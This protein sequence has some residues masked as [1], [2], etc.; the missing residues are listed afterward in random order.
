MSGAAGTPDPRRVVET[1]CRPAVP[2]DGPERGTGYLI[3]PRVV[4][5]ARHAVTSAEDQP[6]RV[7]VRQLS[8]QADEDWLDVAEVV[9]PASPGL[10]IALLLLAGDAPDVTGDPGVTAGIADLA[11]PVPFQA[12]GFPRAHRLGESRV[13]E[14]AR[15]HIRLD[16]GSRSAM[17]PLDVTSAVPSAGR[18]AVP[19]TGVQPK[20]GWLG[21]SGAAVIGPGNL[22]VGVA[23]TDHLR[24]EA[25]RLEMVPVEAVLADEA[26]ARHLP[27][28]WLVRPQ[29]RVSNQLPLAIGSRRVQLLAPVPRT[30]ARKSGRNQVTT[31]LDGRSG[32]VPFVPRVPEQ[33][34]LRRWCD[35]D[36]QPVSF[37]VLS[38]EGGAGKSRLARQ[39]CDDLTDTGWITGLLQPSPGSGPAVP[40]E[41]AGRPALLVLD[42]ADHRQEEVAQLLD[43]LPSLGWSKV[44]VLAVVRDG[45]AFLH[46]LQLARAGSI[47]SVDEKR[48]LELAARPLNFQERQQHYRAAIRAFAEDQQLPLPTA[49]SPP[50]LE[51]RLAAVGTPLLVHAAAL[52]DLLDPGLCG[53]KDPEDVLRHLLDREDL[54]FWE[55]DFTGLLES[56]DTRRRVIAVSTFVSVE[57]AAD[58]ENLAQALA[59]LGAAG[60]P[61]STRDLVAERMKSRYGRLLPRVEPDLLGEQLIADSVVRPGRLAAVVDQVTAAGPRSRMLEVLLRMCGS[62]IG[63]VQQD[64]R[65]ALTRVLDDHL[66]GLLRQA[67]EQTAA[68]ASPGPEARAMPSRLASCIDIAATPQAAARALETVTFPDRVAVQVLA[69][70]VY[71]AAARDAEAK[72][73]FAAAATLDAK[74]ATAKTRAGYLEGAQESIDRAMIYLSTAPAMSV[75]EGKPLARVLSAGSLVSTGLSRPGVALESALQSVRIVEAL[76]D[77]EPGA[78]DVQ[79]LEARQSLVIA[80]I[81][82][83]QVDDALEVARQAIAQS[84]ADS[85][86]P[87]T[88]MRVIQAQILQGRGDLNAAL[89]VIEAGIAEIPDSPTRPRNAELSALNVF[90]AVLLSTLGRIEEAGEAAQ[91]AEEIALRA[92]AASADDSDFILAGTQLGA[93]TVVVSTNGALALDMV[94]HASEALRKLLQRAPDAYGPHYAL[95][96]TLHARILSGIEDMAG[97]REVAQR[98]DRFIRDG[99][100]SRPSLYL[101][102]LFMSALT[103]AEIYVS[104]EEYTT[105]TKVLTDAHSLLSRIDPSVAPLAEGNCAFLL[106]SLADVEMARED[107]DAAVLAARHALV[108]FDALIARQP[109]ADHILGRIGTRL[110]LLTALSAADRD[111]ELIGEAGEALADAERLMETMPSDQSRIILGLA[112]VIVAAGYEQQGNVPEAIA[113]LHVT[114]DGLHF[115]H[116]TSATEDERNAVRQL[117]RDLEAPGDRIASDASPEKFEDLASVRLG[118]SVVLGTYHG[119][120]VAARPFRPV[121]VLGPQRSRKT[122]GVIIPALLEWQ[123]PVLVTSVR[124]DV[125][126]GSIQRRARMGGRSWVF[127]PFGDLFSGAE[128]P[129]TTWNPVDGCENWESAVRMAHWL[130]E[131]GHTTDHAGVQDFA[132][133]YSQSTLLLG[134]LL[135]AAALSG[136]SMDA[137]SRWARTAERAEVIARLEVS[138]AHPESI[139]TFATFSQLVDMTR[140]G[141]YAT[142]RTVL[143]AYESESV[144]RNSVTGFRPEEFF[145]G[146]PNTLYLCAPP[147]EQDLLAPIF[148][149]LVKTIVARAYRYQ[150]DNLN[151]LLLLDEAGNIARI[152]NLNTLATTA[153]GTKIQLVTVFHDLSQM[154]ALYGQSRASNIANNHSAL[155]ILPGT[156]DEATMHY[157]ERLLRDESGPARFTAQR[158]VRQLKPGTALCVYEHLKIEEIK[159][160]SSTHDPDLVALATAAL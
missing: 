66:E 109:V 73:D 60:S 151:L 55:K 72:E 141:V 90:R 84:P 150:G 61:A 29:P 24:F 11:T 17:V 5:T 102:P 38:G 77:R 130:T 159:L 47:D 157:A 6:G 76:A 160:R 65:V 70:E 149:A 82:A 88:A 131:A 18:A 119:Q 96:E 43:L 12:C 7:R 57:N 14:T 138:S 78:H 32:V 35:T 74:A 23:V 135:H 148:T 71:A 140:D 54:R 16:S 106:R 133:W 44:R 27:E 13:E 80:H 128:V 147:D 85:G 136:L 68:N 115:D 31:L 129:T 26:L 50:Q 75:T 40:F 126:T 34:F 132:F 142:L 91:D 20:S 120:E 98:A 41:N 89:E 100:A 25:D 33:Q 111:D 22:L 139:A 36:S 9:T 124:D 94:E 48:H 1:M 93:A 19:E 105:A 113:L 79:L 8:Q 125:V 117:I 59:A 158:S 112:R 116:E 92:R 46:R 56:P 144:R 87:R 53:V 121:L 81:A 122:T 45:K 152:D 99:F 67:I 156:R 97:A 127:E 134:P 37:A 69:A 63:T 86:Q 146:E 107:Y 114:L 4:L 155:L 103:L 28:A 110:L 39:L 123:G 51:Q 101:G 154:E 15:G 153:A 3:T 49:L 145:N 137:V 2:E 42:Y 108:A 58:S 52:L 95:A 62:P 30:H 64:T 118:H 143:R 21:M 104:D 83:G 10:D